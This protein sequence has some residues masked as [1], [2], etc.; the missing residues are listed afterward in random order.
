[1]AHPHYKE[2]K[3]KEFKIIKNHVGGNCKIIDN[4]FYPP[5]RTSE[6]DSKKS[7]AIKKI[8]QILVTVTLLV[9][10]Q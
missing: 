3:R 4:D 1:M 10:P 7:V 5:L 2:S 6:R 9:L 8:L